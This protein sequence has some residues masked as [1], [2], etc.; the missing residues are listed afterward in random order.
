M[1]NRNVQI[2]IFENDVSFLETGC[3]SDIGDRAKQEDAYCVSFVKGIFLATVCDG[4]GGYFGG[5]YASK[6]AVNFLHTKFEKQPEA[7]SSFFINS[8]TDI[9][10][11]VKSLKTSDEH[12]VKGGTTIV[13]VLID[14]D[15]INWFSVGDSRLYIIRNHEMIQVT[16]DHNYGE[17][18]I[19]LM[20][21]NKIKQSQI[22]M[23]NVRHDALTSYVGMGGI[24]IF[25]ISLSDFHL[26]NDDVII[27]MS[28]G[29]Y[30]S[31]DVNRIS[32]FQN[33]EVNEMINSILRIIETD[34]TGKR[35]NTTFILIK[36]HNRMEAYNETCKM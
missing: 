7:D 32:L 18:L 8:L 2:R 10:S 29:L 5:E 35:D 14:G 26:E 15:R 25:D 1:Y 9:D 31:I 20:K 24:K 4:M 16:K 22:D 3:Y 12:L 17:R 19:E 6:A 33:A 36:Y 13:S 28:D 23:K 30:K 34:N 21:Q 27:L 11:E